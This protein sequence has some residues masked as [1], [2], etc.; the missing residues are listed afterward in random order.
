MLFSPRPIIIIVGL[1]GLIILV[2]VNVAVVKPIIV[3]SM[4]TI[5]VLLLVFTKL[6][7]VFPCGHVSWWR[8]Q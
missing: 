3:T 4:S 6:K 5:L 1:V 7:L 8:P 2:I